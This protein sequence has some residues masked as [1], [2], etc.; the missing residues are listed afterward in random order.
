MT[1]DFAGRTALVTGGNSGIGRAVAGQLAR[2]G[3]HVVI[4]GRDVARGNRAVGEIRAEGGTADFVQADLADVASVRSLAKQAVELGGGQVDVLINNA[5]I[6]PFGAT[7]E[8]PESDF[9]AVYAVNVRAPFYLV[10]ELAPL[11][12]ARG[13]GA[14]VNVTTIVAYVGMAGMAAYGSSK[15]AVEL[16]TRAWA[17]EFGPAGV[18][19]NAVSPGPIRTEGTAVMGENLDNLAGTT[20]LQ[21]VGAPDEVAEGIVFLASDAASLIHGATLPIDGGRLAV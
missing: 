17:A 4:G 12:A 10:A 8:V 14:I 16:L 19:V 3:A 9:D 2:R 11:M 21:R 15:A 13:T 6:F 20:P 18:R 7:A 5:G 1:Q